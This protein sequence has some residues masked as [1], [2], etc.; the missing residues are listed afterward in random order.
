MPCP[1]AAGFGAGRVG[2]VDGDVEAGLV[3]LFFHVDLSGFLERQEVGPHPRDFGERQAFLGDVNGCAHEVR[4]GDIAR[5]RSGVTVNQ[6]ETA[7]EL[8]GAHGGVYLKRTVKADPVRMGRIG[9]KDCSPAT[10]TAAVRGQVRIHTQLGA[11]RNGHQLSVVPHPVQ[12]GRVLDALEPFSLTALVLPLERSQRAD[13]RRR[14]IEVSVPHGDGRDG[15]GHRYV[16]GICRTA[17]AGVVMPDAMLRDT[18]LADAVPSEVVS[19]MMLSDL[20]LCGGMIRRRLLCRVLSRGMLGR[21]RN[22]V[23]HGRMLCLRGVLGL[24]VLGV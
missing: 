16:D 10:R 8:N 21:G 19:D 14:H 24:R 12:L 1:L 4:R 6:D 15:C 18:V 13:Q 9:E 23:L 17:A 7:L 5:G 2:L 22:R 11:Y 3:E 20:V